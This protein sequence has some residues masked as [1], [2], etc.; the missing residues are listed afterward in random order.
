[1]IEWEKI[2]PYKENIF[3]LRVSLEYR[4][5]F[6]L[7]RQGKEV[8][9]MKEQKLQGPQR[10]VFRKEQR[11]FSLLQILTPIIGV[12]CII[13]VFINYARTTSEQ[14]VEKTDY[15]LVQTSEMIAREIDAKVAYAQSS[16]RSIATYVAMEMQGDTLLNP[17]AT[18][19]PYVKDTP[20][21][22]IEYVQADGMNMMNI[23]KP[24]DASQREYYIQ[25][26]QGKTGIW[27][28]YHPKYSKETL[29]NFYTPL[30]RNDRICG[31]V[32][33]LIGG[34]AQISPLLESSFFGQPTIGLLIDR[35]HMVI[36]STTKKDYIPKLSVA[37]LMRSNGFNA[38][39]IRSFYA[40][41]A[42]ATKGAMS[43]DT[44]N[45]TARVCVAEVP[46]TG[47]LVVKVVPAASFTAVLNQS[48][49]A[50]KLTF[51]CICFILFL[52]IYF[53]FY[54]NNKEK[55]RIFEENLLLEEENA[56]FNEENKRAF[57]EIQE[58]R[59]AAE[60]ANAAKTTFLSRMSHDIRT[61]L[62]GII[63]L[64]E[65]NEKHSE[66][67]E[68]LQ[69]NGQKMK[70]AA[71]HLLALISDILDL[72]KL[73]DEKVYFAHEP[74]NLAELLEEVLTISATK[75][76]ENGISLVKDGEATAI[77]HPFVYGSPLHV[78]QVLLNI[79]NNGI[80]YNKPGGRVS[81]SV[82]ESLL[83]KEKVL[84][85]ITI[86]DDGI[87]MGE[88]YLQHIFEPFT[89]EHHDARSFYQGTGLGMA[90]VK[91]LID[92]MG[93]TIQVHSKQGQGTSFRLVL[94]FALATAADMPLHKNEVPQDVLD[95]RI[96]LVEDNE[97]NM[98][99]ASIILK[100]AGVKVSTAE[101]G[102]Q[103][104]DL[105]AQQPPNSFDLVLMDVMMPVMDGLAATRAIRALPRE[106]LQH[107]P[108][109]AMTANAFK[110]DVQNCL[111]AGMNDHLA[112]PLD[113]N[114]LL[115]LLAKYK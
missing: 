61:P 102:Q 3:R 62:N 23:G 105:L 59:A 99:I 112:K 38:D 74:F 87:G 95:M 65:I 56:R 28:N 77:A 34:T 6:V 22:L 57:Q 2:F 49:H 26:I 7:C 24:F 80:K 91:S 104:V 100:D 39:Q 94:P 5:Y 37:D 46:S 21:E 63:G 86:A 113:I 115:Q 36:A 50:A 35:G 84:Y 40:L 12:L 13:L 71:K 68:L 69:A 19:S 11:H 67:R 47:W 30:I 111:A 43:F 52:Y 58:A 33:G 90:I 78:R 83:A 114:K 101:N 14:M 92:K 109:I 44:P 16:I 18:I 98:E 75:A 72:S 54:E 42:A 20:F 4:K 15:T 76:A 81:C 55:Q 82:R 17:Q 53:V 110:E 29:L 93:G 32:T 107:L 89:Q 41:T 31:V 96:L 66:D 108:I 70:V 45:G 88:D 10:K 103:A 9:L 64:L 48:T 73:D 60:R 106:D 25:G 97:L 8:D 79:I 27:N 1:M 51:A 85:E